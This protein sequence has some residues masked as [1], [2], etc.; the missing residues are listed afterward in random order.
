[1][2][3]LH[4][5]V[6]IFIVMAT[7]LALATVASGTINMTPLSTAVV[8]PEAQQ[9]MAQAAQRDVQLMDFSSAD[10]VDPGLRQIGCTDYIDANT[11]D[12]FMYDANEHLIRQYF[13]SSALGAQK[14]V[15]DPISLPASEL[16]GIARDEA[17]SRLSFDVPDE[18][19]TS[20]DTRTSVQNKDGE[21]LQWVVEFREY[22][23]S[24]K[25]ENYVR[26]ALD[27]VSGDLLWLTQYR[28]STPVDSSD[29]VP[30]V[31]K[32]TAIEA[33]AAELKVGRY[34]VQR[35]EPIRWRAPDGSPAT[36]V[37]DIKLVL[38]GTTEFLGGGVVDAKTGEV[39]SM[40][41]PRTPPTGSY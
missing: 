2:K 29:L 8:P 20:Y 21:V 26:I 28:S 25:S 10:G 15:K 32:E 11:R 27:P 22:L 23:S 13:S 35:A 9:A 24:T 14:P 39:L 12:L 17:R 34:D 4:R 36:L 19:K 18:W 41:V 1:M 33:I 37:W 3:R 30:V 6:A 31:T 5:V 38:P 40:G 16:L 7:F